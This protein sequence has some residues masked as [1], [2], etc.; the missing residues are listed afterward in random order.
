MRKLALGLVLTLCGGWLAPLFAAAV[1]N[2]A[3]LTALLNRIGGQGTADRFT[4]VVDDA[5]STD[6]KDVFVLSSDGS[7]P[8]ISGS[9]ALAAATGINW[10]LNHYAHVNL[11]WNQLTTDL[12]T[13]SLPTPSVEEKRTCEADYR[14]Y[15]N[16]CTFS[17]SMCT[18]TWERWQEEIDWMAL[19][20]INMPLQIIGLDVLWYNLL[21]KDL[22]YTPEEAND[23]IAGPS[24]QA[25]WGMNNL[26]GWGGP[27][28]DWWYTRQE[29]LCKNILAR[30]RELDMDP[31]LPGYA[32]MVPSNIGEKGYTAN[33]QGN[34][35][36]YVR[37]YI[38]DPNSSAF[39]TVSEKYY[40]RL[41]ELMGTSTYYSLDPFHEGANTTGI[42]VPAAYDKLYGAMEKAAPGSKWVIQYW[43]WHSPQYNVL[44]KVPQGRLIVLDLFSDNQPNFGSYKVN[45]QEGVMHDAV[46][47]SLANFGGRTGLFGR[48]NKV[49]DRYY[50]DKAAHA[51]IKGIGATPEA[52]EQVPVLY[53][54]LFEL[55]WRSTKPDAAEW[56]ADY[57]VSRYGVESEDAKAAWEKLRNSAL[58]CTSNLQ[59]PHEAVLCAR[60]AL[61]VGSVSTWGGTGIFYDIQQTI[62]AAHL[63]KAAGLTGENYS[64]D[65]TDVTRQA[66]TDYAYYLLAAIN[67]ANAA[68]DTEAFAR[69]RDH[70]LQLILDLDEL[71]NTNR[72]FMLGHWTETARKIADEA[73]GTTT[74]DKDWLELNNA[75]TIIST[76]GDR[77]QANGGGLKDY[78]YREWGGMMKDYYYPRWKYFFDNNLN[79]T[80]WFVMER[81]WA[82][83]NTKSYSDVPVG[84]TADVAGRLLSKYFTTFKLADGTSRYLYRY[85]EQDCS[86][87]Q[88]YS[89][90]RGE[91]FTMEAVLP[92]GVTATLSV[93]ADNNGSFAETET[94]DGLSIPV[95][96]E[97]V[98][99][100][101]KGRLALSDGTSLLVTLVL[102]DN[103]TTPRT[104]SVAS[105]NTAEGSAAIVGASG[106][107]VT[108][109]DPV[110]MKATPAS[111]FDFQEWVDAAGNPVSKENP[112]TYYGKDAA[113]FTAK[114]LVNKWGTPAEDLVDHGDIKS[115]EQYVTTLTAAR[116]G[117]DP[118]EIYAASEC[119]ATLCHTTDVVEVPRGGKFTLAWKD[120]EAKNGLGYCRLSAYVDVNSDG[121]FDDEGEF[122]AVVGN[123]GTGGNTMLSDASLDVLLPYEVPLGITRVRLRFDGSFTGGWD[124]PSGAKPANA[125]T[126]RMVY[127]VPVNVTEYSSTPCE[128]TVAANPAEGGTA[129]A[130]GEV[131]LTWSDPSVDVILRNSPAD[132][133]VLKGW[134]DQYGRYLPESWID[135]NSIKFKPAESGTFTAQFVKTM[136]ATLSFSGWEFKYELEGEKTTLTEVV[137]QAFDGVLNIP[138]TWEHDGKTYRIV[139]L[140]PRLLNGNGSLTSLSIPETVTYFGE[141][142]EK[143][144]NKMSWTGGAD[145]QTFTLDTP[146][147]SAED[148]TFMAHFTSDGTSFNQWGSV[149]LASGSDAFNGPDF[150]LYLSSGG[151]FRVVYGGENN[152]SLKPGTDFDL[153]MTRKAGE[154]L[155]VTITTGD[156]QTESRTFNAAG[157][158][159]ISVISSAISA[160]STVSDVAFVQDNPVSYTKEWVGEA[161]VYKDHTLPFTLAPTEDWVLQAHV[162][163]DGSS[164][165]QWG[166]AILATGSNPLADSFSGGFQYYL[167]SGGKLTVKVDGSSSQTFSNPTGSSF[168]IA[169]VNSTIWGEMTITLTTVD[170]T[171]E[172]KSFPQAGFQA[173]SQFK[174]ATLAGIKTSLTAVRQG[175][176]LFYGTS[177]EAIS[178][179][180]ANPKYASREGVLYNKDFTT[181]LRV[182]EKLQT[183][184][185]TL[186]ATCTSVADLALYGAQ[187]IGRLVTEQAT[188]LQ[189]LPRFSLENTYGLKLQTSPEQCVAYG[190]TWDAAILVS[191]APGTTVD[192]TKVTKADIL[193]VCADATGSGA[194]TADNTTAERWYTYTFDGTKGVAVAFP[195]KASANF[196]SED[197]KVYAFAD[198]VFEEVDTEGWASIP[199]GNYLL[200]PIEGGAADGKAVTFKLIEEDWA[201]PVTPDP[202]FPGNTTMTMATPANAYTFDGERALFAPATQ[203]APFTAYRVDAAGKALLPFLVGAVTF[204][205]TAETIEIPTNTFADVTM[206]RKLGAGKWNTLC[207][208]FSLSETETAAVFSH[209]E[210]LTSV[211][212]DADNNFVLN[213][214][215]AEAIEAGKPYLVLVNADVTEFTLPEVF[216][217]ATTE[218]QSVE[219]GGVV[220]KG[221]WTPMRLESGEYFIS[222]NMFYRTTTEKWANLKGFRA[223]IEPTGVASEVRQMGIS[224]DGVLTGLDQI[225]DGAGLLPVSVY[226]L[227]G[228]LLRQG[229]PAREAL[230]GLPAGVYMV[231]GKKVI[232]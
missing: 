174:S 49:I 218:L 118:L 214:T 14:Y 225:E 82:L 73:A 216:F 142:T 148:W 145:A 98:T 165:N 119:P 34:W 45:G 117:G 1:T 122:I 210:E 141:E 107:S 152:F 215:E 9:S 37:P 176:A 157:L 70:Y 161:D 115:Y 223:Y 8:K 90:N 76:W 85:F 43:Q 168:D 65:L 52:I 114:F 66:L 188:G 169:M 77:D 35:C 29:Q 227:S 200:L 92:D 190:D 64:Y 196:L 207:L 205:E 26:E 111:G 94:A 41:Q 158:K 25:W 202:A 47:C 109:V 31:V 173:H 58:G 11:A 175:A 93:D 151:V 89:A 226:N 187:S 204:D 84:S 155:T 126:V 7:K 48:F 39:A 136:P 212:T 195:T 53:D 206:K 12:A 116:N 170:G 32:G 24:F 139:A 217:G 88:A 103:I 129:D 184:A 110:E 15:L 177:L 232:K 86:N 221:N 167:S 67:S 220:M 87:E 3:A 128:I 22:G 13:I 224:I 27:N 189:E 108:N 28:P 137:S 231:N 131:A 146:M 20:G 62:G 171:T 135:G 78:S 19:H 36:G 140:A 71:L 178:V 229:V 132:G 194:F 112:Y 51:H 16:Y 59:G 199:A 60:P 83:D 186:P 138:A 203:V 162:E 61:S 182:P 33:N 130:N 159:D 2:P 50:A 127:D 150:Q 213:F 154:S 160:G 102:K 5:L 144:L 101:V 30:M 10:Y 133:Y 104:V 74:A 91:T 99:G 105:A 42:D 181:L 211:S 228:V 191:A 123:I 75:R 6:G 97:A 96:A 230:Q 134:T 164:F 222:N 80:D 147:K 63:L 172:S 185:V 197:Y 125:E 166:S 180:A 57:T 198:G 179:D 156:G 46:W 209:V 55:P 219:Q 44:N 201:W 100:R 163:T 149:L 143:V 124:G 106:T 68:K 121:D 18:W 81:A 23:F 40:A 69:T 153:E 4:I 38:L 183:G 193:E 95:P 17:Y 208:P 21:T 56:M 120:T 113:S 79:G 72:M 54:A 192:A